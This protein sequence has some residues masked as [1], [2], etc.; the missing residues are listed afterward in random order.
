MNS[1]LKR[2]I[3][4]YLDPEIKQETGNF[5]D[6]INDS[7]ANYEEQIAMLQRAM[8]ISSDELY[9]ANSRLREEAKSL[10]EIN[11]NLESILHS[12]NPD[13]DGIENTEFNVTEYIKKQSEEII[14]INKQREE[15]LQ[16]LELQNQ[17]LNE[18]AH[19]V[20]HDLKSPLRNVNTLVNWI[21]EDNGETLTEDSKDSLNLVLSNVE[22]MDLIIKGILDYSSI[23]KLQSE[24]RIVDFN[25]LISEIIR[26]TS[27]PEHIELKKDNELPKIYGNYH[28]FKQ[29]F[30]SLIN[31][32]I[33]YNDKEKGNINIGCVYKGNM[34]EFYIKDN[35]IGIPEA[36]FDKIFN[37]FTKLENDN[38]SSGI[39]LSIVKKIISFY[40][41]KIW[42]ESELK[43]GTTFFFTLKQN[44][45]T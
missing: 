10:K 12:M 9:E 26:T 15:L 39:G 29:L 42:L 36:Y 13:S 19:V 31:N 17:E 37:V 35:G 4:K 7:Y 14:S 32:A 5:L 11:K 8:K 34:V 2:Q 45:T 38:H 43:K 1:L 3:R 18:Y 20:S 41:G 24:S 27:L 28:R 44:G 25:V 33:K 30:Q 40:G 23:D 21:I 22:K 6:A 16:N